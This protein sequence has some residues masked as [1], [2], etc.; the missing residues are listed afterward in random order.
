MSKNT[1]FKEKVSFLV[2]G[3]FRW[4]HYFYSFSWF[5]L[6]WSKKKFWPKQIVCTK[7]RVFSPFLTQIVSPN[8]CQKS[9]F[10]DFSHFWMTTAKKP[11]FY[12]VFWPF[13]FCLFFFLLFLFFQHK[14]D[15]N[16][17]CNFLFENL[18]FD[19]PKILQKH[20]FCTM[21]HYLCF[22][23]CPKK[24]YKNGKTMKKNL[25]H[26]LTLNL[27]HFLTLK[28]PNLGPLFNFTQ[29]IYIYMH[30]LWSYYLVQVWPF[31]KLLSGPSL[32]FL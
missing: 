7:M 27:D 4:N 15:K 6:F 14:K 25:D 16:K 32:L 12:R 29:H 17:K 28:P 22:Q 10:W 3:N 20:Y 8:F 18:I 13:P 19:I 31:W 26:F 11:Y 9:I 24:H 2:L 1:F 5:A 30:M 21:W 23:K